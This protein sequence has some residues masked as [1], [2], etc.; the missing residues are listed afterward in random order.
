[1]QSIDPSL[2]GGAVSSI[3]Y[4]GDAIS[5]KAA[6]NAAKSGLAVLNDLSL[7]EPFATTLNANPNGRFTQG[8]YVT[9]GQVVTMVPSFPS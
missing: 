5:S 6:R 9:G 8:W 7:F 4:R 3:N 2:V 1:M